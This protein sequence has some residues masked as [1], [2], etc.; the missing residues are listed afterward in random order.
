MEKVYKD[1]IRIFLIIYFFGEPINNNPKFTR[2][3]KSEVK[4]Q[5]IHFLIRNPDY[6]AYELL[7][8]S[9]KKPNER[10]NIK[11]IV[12][13]I[14]KNKEPKLKKDEMEK[15]FFGAYESID[16]I[17]SFLTSLDLIK[18]ESK[19]SSSMK[20][21]EKEYY[22][23]KKGESFFQNKK[24]EKNT[25]ANW[26]FERC[27]LIKRYFGIYS[28]SELKD[29]QYSIEEYKETKYNDFIREITSNV[30]LKYKKL[31]KKELI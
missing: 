26:Y 12:D 2:L 15:Y 13:N 27:D 5:K 21:I 19:R 14:F 10:D 4:I 6:L 8:I 16:E 7:K 29:L 20:K 17:I 11:L 30:K 25:H 18:F 3:L 28:G 23:T 9:E 22:I 1:R 31:Y 24:N